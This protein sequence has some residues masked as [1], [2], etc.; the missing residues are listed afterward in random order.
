MSKKIVISIHDAAPNFTNE[1]KIIF[2]ALDDL[3]VKKRTNLIVP[4]FAKKIF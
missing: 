4:N 1:L 2:K 3:G